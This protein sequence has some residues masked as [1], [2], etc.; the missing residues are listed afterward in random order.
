MCFCE[1]YILLSD[2]VL[3]ETFLSA[4]TLSLECVGDVMLRVNAEAKEN[5][6]EGDRGFVVE[7]L[8]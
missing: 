8:W 2:W 5:V 7:N 1:H 4:C 6:L 3:T